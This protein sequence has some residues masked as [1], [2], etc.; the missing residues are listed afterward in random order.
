[1]ATLIQPDGTETTVTPKDTANGFTLDELYAL[2][3]CESIEIP[4]RDAATD[5]VMVID[6]EG[7]LRAGGPRPMNRKA[8]YVLMAAGGM[9]GDYIAGPALLA[10]DQEVQ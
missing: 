9:T 4:C 10:T 1:M 3:G 2:L 7:K 6:E 8:T 5:R